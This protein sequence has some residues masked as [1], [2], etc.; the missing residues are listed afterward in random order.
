MKKILRFFLD[1]TQVIFISSLFF[2]LRPFSFEFISNL[3]GALGRKIGMKLPHRKRAYES[4]RRA[5]PELSTQKQDEIVAGMF[6]NLTRTLLEYIAFSKIHIYAPNSRVEVIGQEIIDQ[7]RDDQK[8]AILFLAHLANWEVGTLA[9]IQRGL[10]LIQVYRKLNYPL[11][12]KLIHWIHRRVAQEVIAKGPEGARQMVQALKKGEHISMLTDQKMNEGEW[13]PFFGLRA[14]TPSGGAR[15]AL[16]Y[17]CPFVPVRVERIEG[18]RFRVTYYPPIISHK[19][20]ESEQ[21]IDLLE[22]MNQL[23]ESWIRERPDQWFWLHQRWPKGYK[24]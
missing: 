13:I 22:Q 9:S 15:L 12:D 4:L 20:T 18:V 3:G 16:K 1:I 24:A 5:M 21:L 11:T 23:I 2:F 17:K 7:L 19:K 8:P 10:N 14:K 6:D